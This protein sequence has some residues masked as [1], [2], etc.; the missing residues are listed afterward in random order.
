MVMARQQ[1]IGTCFSLVLVN[2]LDFA[3]LLNP[4]NDGTKRLQVG[5]SVDQFA[6]Y[7]L[8]LIALLYVVNLYVLSRS[9]DMQLQSIQSIHQDVQ[10]LRP[11][12]GRPWQR[13]G[14]QQVYE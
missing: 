6:A 5:L 4:T 11:Y 14:L 13:M 9:N 10:I 8:A 2:L 7:N 1:A 12:L 3:Q